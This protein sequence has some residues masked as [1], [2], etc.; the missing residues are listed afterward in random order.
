MKRKIRVGLD[1]DGVVAYNPFR[2]VRAPWAFFK[3]RILGIRKLTFFYPKTN[4]SKFIWKLMHDSSIFPAKGKNLLMDLVN[5]DLIE[6][7]LVS[8]RFS[9]LDDHLYSWLDRYGMRKIFKSINWNRKDKQ[10]HK[11]KEELIRNK[12]IEIFVEDNWD[13]VEYLGE[14][15][16]N[17]GKR[18]K[19]FWIYNLV[20]RLRK[21]EYKYPYLEKALE[22]II[23]EQ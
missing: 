19:I 7:H 2:I 8:G 14:S 23:K 18:V 10:P 21:Y 6:V 3:S 17:Y 9:F 5:N 20:D 11:F 16:K 1:F 15:N 4:F 13:I 12:K 22:A